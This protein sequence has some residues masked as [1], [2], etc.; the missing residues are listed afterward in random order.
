LFGFGF[1]G[2]NHILQMLQK[3]FEQNFCSSENEKKN[4]LIQISSWRT[5]PYMPLVSISMVDFQKFK[6]Y[7]AINP[8]SF[9]Q[10]N[11]YPEA[12]SFHGLFIPIE[13]CKMESPLLMD[14]Y[15]IMVRV[16]SET[17]FQHMNQLVTITPC[18]LTMPIV[19]YIMD[20]VYYMTHE[21]IAT[22]PQ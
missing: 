8:P 6:S 7:I 9:I 2:R 3:C 21:Y 22:K 20:Q 19:V 10:V 1:T 15:L 4:S 17:D 5:K 16:I 13:L 18:I 11:T 14:S 12:W